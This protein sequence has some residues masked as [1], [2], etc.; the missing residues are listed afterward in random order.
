MKI[1]AQNKKVIIGL[2]GGRDSA[3]AAALLKKADFKVVGIFMR[4]GNTSVF[5]QGEK[6]ARQIASFLKIDYKCL[7]LRKEFE[8]EIIKPFI[9]EHKQGKT[10]NPC[11][12]CNKEIK[13]DVLFKKMKEFQADFMATGHYARIKNQ[14]LLKAKDSH[15]D[16][17]YFLWQLTPKLLSKTLFPLAGYTKTEVSRLAK[18]FNL[19]LGDVSDSQEICFIESSLANFFRIHLKPKAGKILDSKGKVIG[20]HKG[21]WQYTLGQ[22]KGIGFSG[23]PYYV[24]NKDIKKNAL[25]V[26][27]NERELYQKELIAKDVNWIVGDE[28]KFPLK[29]KARIRYHGN[30]CSA[31]IDRYKGDKVKIVFA[32]PQRAVTPGQSVVFYDKQELLGGGT[33]SQ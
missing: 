5:K 13:F 2:S 31:V 6:R 14:K 11:V 8:Q 1:Q 23:G 25:I 9:E 17:S 28:L 24:V 12:V 33:I 3:V 32:K 30:L 29:A 22:R 21:L 4:L 20:E 10:P 19:P 27:K 7:D 26:S 16:Q 15:K 18:D